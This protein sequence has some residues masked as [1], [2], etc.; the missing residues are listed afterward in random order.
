MHL[1]FKPTFKQQYLRTI[2]TNKIGTLAELA[3][4]AA[5]I[6]P[7]PPAPPAEPQPEPELEPPM[8]P[9][10]EPQPE[11]EAIRRAWDVVLE[12]FFIERL[13]SMPERL[14][15]VIA[16]HYLCFCFDFNCKTGGRYITSGGLGQISNLNTSVQCAALIYEYT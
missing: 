10:A 8:P 7:S 12:E 11:P 2:A 3:S 16:K 6:L 13:N 1:A 14:A 9:L 5:P 15:A 4:V